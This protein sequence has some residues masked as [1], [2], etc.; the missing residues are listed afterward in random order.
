MASEDTT[1]PFLT[2]EKSQVLQEW[3]SI[4]ILS[5]SS[6]ACESNLRRFSS[7]LDQNASSTVTTLA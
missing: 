4:L 3:I 6:P 1:E 5:F 7:N 2:N